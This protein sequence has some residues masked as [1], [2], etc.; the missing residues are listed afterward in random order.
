[1]VELW[2]AVLS[3]STLLEKESVPFHTCVEIIN[4]LVDVSSRQKANNLL[5][6]I[7]LATGLFYQKL[8]RFEYKTM[9]ADSGD[10]VGISQPIKKVLLDDIT[11]GYVLASNQVIA[12]N[13]G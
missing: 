2:L 13:C 10:D 5:G 4:A 12:V 3:N 1:M 8:L 11:V 7:C 9:N 6:T